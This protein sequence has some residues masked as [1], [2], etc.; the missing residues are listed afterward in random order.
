MFFLFDLVQNSSSPGGAAAALYQ[1]HDDGRIYKREV[2]NSDLNLIKKWLFSTKK[3]FSEGFPCKTIMPSWYF[4]MIYFL[5]SLFVYERI[6]VCIFNP[7]RHWGTAWYKFIFPRELEHKYFVMLVLSPCRLSRLLS[8]P[9]L[10]TV[11]LF[12]RICQ[13]QL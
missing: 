6:D 7:W 4:S 2:W 9:L 8:N 5:F 11:N 13:K 12:L 3:Y 1:D 10:F